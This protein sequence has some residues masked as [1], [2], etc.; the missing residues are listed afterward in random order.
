LL[1][2]IEIQSKATNLIHIIEVTDRM[3]VKNLGEMFFKG[4]RSQKNC[5]SKN[6]MLFAFN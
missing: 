1:E 3:L 5:Y 6:K 4:L 2:N